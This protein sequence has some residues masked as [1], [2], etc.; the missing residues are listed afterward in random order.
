[1]TTLLISI[2]FPRIRSTSADSRDKRCRLAP[3]L[4]A[5]S[6]SCV[7]SRKIGSFLRNGS[8]LKY[9]IGSLASLGGGILIGRGRKRGLVVVQ[10]FGF[11]G[12]GGGGTGW[13]K[14][15][16]T[17]VLGNLALAIGLAYLSMTGQLGW[18]LDA[19]VSIWLFAV[20]LPIVGLGAFFWFAGRDIVQSSCPNC[21]NDF[22]IF[23]SSLKDGPQLCPFCTQPFSVQGDKFVRESAKFSSNRASTFG[24]VFS[25]F[26]QQSEK[27]KASSTMTTIVDIEAEVKDVD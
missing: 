26:T 12:D 11:N 14:N 20:L 23:K 17:R 4:Y 16:T 3:K 13:D 7:P 2:N 1:M 19:I 24:Q 6:Y 10:G 18:I 9:S 22:Q 21:G 8:N 27:G 5:L 15:N 25:G